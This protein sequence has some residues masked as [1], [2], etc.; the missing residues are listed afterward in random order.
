MYVS[1]PPFPL[2]HLLFILNPYPDPLAYLTAK[3]NGLDEIALEILEAAGL[4]E[5]DV[6][7]VPSFGTSTLRPPSVIT[8]TADLNWPSISTGESFFER[9]LVNGNL[10]GGSD[11]PYVNG[12]DAGAA[13]SS[14]L[15]EWAK[16]EEAEDDV[17]ADEDGWD[18]DAGGDEVAAEAEKDDEEEAEED[19]GA[20]ANPGI[21]ETE[22]WTRNSPFAGDH[23]AA[24]SFDTA[25]QVSSQLSSL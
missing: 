24:G 2:P 17:V 20:G 23:V 9:A 3:T 19:L 7:D 6:D 5:A 10:E 14:A 16:E 21:S 13:A 4:T 11:A 22:L 15:D 18:L 8:S 12:H 25:M 1:F